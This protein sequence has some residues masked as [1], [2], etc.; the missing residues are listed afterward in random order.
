MPQKLRYSRDELLSSHPYAKPHEEAG[1]KLHGGFDA[2]GQYISPAHP[3]SAGP[4]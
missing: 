1:Y 2:E 3:W 4:R